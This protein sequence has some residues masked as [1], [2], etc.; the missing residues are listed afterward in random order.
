MNKPIVITVK[1]KHGQPKEVPGHLKWVTNSPID[2][3]YNTC[4]VE[5]VK[6]HPIIAMLDQVKPMSHESFN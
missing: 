5:I 2:K 1:G 6:G 4:G 3:K